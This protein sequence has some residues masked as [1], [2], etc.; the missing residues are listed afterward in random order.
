MAKGAD[1][2]EGLDANAKRAVDQT[3]MQ[4]RDAV[5]NYFSFLQQMISSYPSGGTDLGEKLKSYAMQSIA[6]THDFVT[7]LSQAKDFQDAVRIQTEFMQT[8]MK[9][10]GQQTKNLGD[11]FT[12]A[13]TG[14]VKIPF[15]GS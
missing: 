14:A 11:E 8:Q 10:F 9:A 13:A 15:K 3:L 5:D 12:K 7:K 1:P 2:L 6:A 4:T